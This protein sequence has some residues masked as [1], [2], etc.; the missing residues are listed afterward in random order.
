M[1][2]VG[3]SETWDHPRVCGSTYFNINADGSYYVGSDIG[4]SDSIMIIVEPKE[5][6]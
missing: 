3:T 1:P 6:K 4:L 5:D 2:T